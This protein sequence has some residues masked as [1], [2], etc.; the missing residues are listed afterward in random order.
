VSEAGGRTGSI[1]TGPGWRI[2]AAAPLYEALA[3]LPG[4]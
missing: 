3:A 4:A 2:A 1:P